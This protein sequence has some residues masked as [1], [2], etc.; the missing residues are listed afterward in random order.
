M[1]Q[2][3]I[4]SSI[5]DNKLPIKNTEIK[6]QV[7]E[8]NG[9]KPSNVN[10]IATSMSATNGQDNGLNFT[11]DN[12][13]Y[14]KE[15]GIVTIKAQNASDKIMWKKNAQD[16][17]LVTYI[18]DGQEIY[19]YAK[20]NGVST[21]AYTSANIAVYNNEETNIVA[22]S[23]STSIKSTKRIG[24]IADFDI[25]LTNELSKGQIYANYDSSKKKEVEYSEKYVSTINSVE[26]TDSI[27]FNQ[28]VD[29]FMTKDNKEAPTTVS[30]NNYTYNKSVSIDVDVFN[31]ILGED[32]SI[33]VYNTSDTKLGTINKS[34][35]NKDG[36][37]TLDISDKN[38]NQI[39]IIASKPQVEGQLIINVNKAI[40]TNID[41]SKSQMQTFTK[42]QA[43]LQGKA[44]TSTVEATITIKRNK[45]SCK[46]YNR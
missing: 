42:M 12:Y 6:V 39:Y 26:L 2:T 44:S 38:T 29:S 16:E 40:K 1:L 34:T 28:Q 17:Y 22:E 36:K 10:V 31:K 20:T 35:E 32:G 43:G 46:Y 13:T 7:P 24:T 14:D 8:I 11:Y 45:F 9:N 37:Y 15:T 30:G 33:D 18:Y 19:N 41:Y 3:K 4:N 25:Y 27:R 5:V 21:L 23:I